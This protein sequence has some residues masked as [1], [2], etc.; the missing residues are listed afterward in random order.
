[1]AGRLCAGGGDTHSRRGIF[2][3]GF[4]GAE[5]ICLQRAILSAQIAL[6]DALA[7]AAQALTNGA[8][9]ICDRGALDG[10][11]YCSDDQ[12]TQILAETGLSEETLLNRY[13]GIFHLPTLAGTDAYGQFAADNP[14]RFESVA[15]AISTDDRLLEAWARHPRRVI[16][17]CDAPVENKVALIAGSVTTP[18]S[19]R[20]TP[21]P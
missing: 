9:M 1:M 19:P 14:C 10:K 16:L 5:K 20:K 11:A 4:F 8:I 18:V 21:I 17:P 13:E 12:W 15:E 7:G 2:D 6:E 3:C